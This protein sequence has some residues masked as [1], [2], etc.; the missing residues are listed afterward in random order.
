MRTRT[1]AV[2]AAVAL[3][4]LATACADGGDTGTGQ[5]PTTGAEQPVRG[6]TLVVALDGQDPGNLNPAVTSNGGVHTASEPM[7]NGLVGLDTE[8]RP[9]PELAESW[10]VEQNGAVYRF[11]LRDNVR[12]HDGRTLTS[13]D[14]VFTFTNALLR[15]HSRTAA[16]MN[17]AQVRVEAPDPRTVVFTFAAPY[18]PLLQQLNVTEAPIIPRHVYEG[19]SDISTVAGCPPNRAPVGTG[20]FKFVS[21]DAN[22]IRLERNP[23]YFRQGLPYLDGIVQRFIADQGTKTLALQAG[24]VDWAWGVQG[25]DLATLRADRNITLADAARGPGGGNCVLTVAFNLRPPAGRTNFFSDLRVRQALWHAT[26]RQQAY[27]QIQFGQ[28]RVATQPIHTAIPVARATGITLP[29]FDAARARTLLDQAGWREPSPGAIRVAQ[30]VQGVPDGTELRI[31]FHGFAGT[32]IEYGQALRQ[33]WRAVGVEVE[34]RQEDNPTLSANVFRDRQFDT[35]AISYCNEA[36]PLI[37]VRRQ[38]HSSQ[39]SQTAFTNASGYS[40]PEMDQLWDQSTAEA[41][42]GRRQQLFQQIQQMAVRD[43]PYI[44][45]VE[46]ANTRAWRAECSGFNIHNTGLFAEA[47][48]CRQ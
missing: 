26:N 45:L 19:C 32:Q 21:A 1:S 3:S 43:L 20:P 8:G 6:G 22:E 31:D 5:T 33:Q 14:V 16:S 48:Y 46:S 10:A 30:G 28:G 13:D 44:W 7:F 36:D 4:L 24:E 37:G 11:T 39:I 41:D 17:A 34:T 12:F 2:A 27:D 42:Q 40:T 18:A 9:T 23:D 35:T 47:A 15:Y 25:P 29:A 38:Y